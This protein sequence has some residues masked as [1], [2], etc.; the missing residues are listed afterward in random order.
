MT[1]LNLLKKSLILISTLSLN[2][3]IGLTLAGAAVG[4]VNAINKEHRITKIERQLEKLMK[5]K[6]ESKPKLYVPSYSDMD[7]FNK[8]L[9]GTM[10]P[11]KKDDE[12][13]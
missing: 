8:G 11:E 12:D 9:Y 5:E 13:K 3:C 4:G 6:E 7:S 2:G 10:Y 1:K